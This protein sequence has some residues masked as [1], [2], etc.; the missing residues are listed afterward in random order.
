MMKLKIFILAGE[1]S[2]D[3]HASR[4]MRA[5][6]VLN[7]DTQFIGIGG[8]N[9][10]KE[11][12]ESLVSIEQMSVVGFWEVAKR[13]YFFKKTLEECKRTLVSSD[14]DAFIPVDYPGFNLKLGQFAKKSSIPVYYYIAP[15]LWAWGKGR[16]KKLSTQ[17]DKLFVVF[18][19]EVEFFNNFALMLTS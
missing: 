6:K 4:L 7:P 5:I 9:M 1:A 2:G 19:F 10:E 8:M 17:L 12:L 3:L 14:V 16:A 11:G 18:P 15:Q 13:Y